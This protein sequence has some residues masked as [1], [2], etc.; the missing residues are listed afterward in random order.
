MAFFS[1]EAYQS[2]EGKRVDFVASS[3]F[4]Y[5]VE[6]IMDLLCKVPVSRV[7][8][9]AECIFYSTI[10]TTLYHIAGKAQLNDHQFIP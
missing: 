7:M 4:F 6:N 3:L 5:A 9:G 10:V 8:G 1:A 2:S